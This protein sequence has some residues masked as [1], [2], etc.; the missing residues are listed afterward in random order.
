MGCLV[1]VKEE[2]NWRD[3][4]VDYFWKYNNT[5]ELKAHSIN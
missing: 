5:L 4:S 1:Y 2:R 3:R